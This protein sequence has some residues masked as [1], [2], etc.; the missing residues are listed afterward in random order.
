MDPYPI[1]V[2]VTWAPAILD[3]ATMVPSSA[4]ALRLTGRT[5]PRGADTRAPGAVGSTVGHLPVR[6][7]SGSYAGVGV[8]GL[9][10]DHD[11]LGAGAGIELGHDAVHVGLGG[12]GRDVELF[13]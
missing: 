1:Q 10:G 6:L 12:R 4:P 3:A 5:R 2:G 13:G 7:Q 11:Q 8:A 9:V